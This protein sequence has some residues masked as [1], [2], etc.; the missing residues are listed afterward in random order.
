MSDSPNIVNITVPVGRIE[1]ID[2]SKL[3]SQVI[4]VDLP[5]NVIKIQEG[6]TTNII[7]TTTDTSTITTETVRTNV[8][9]VI[10]QG[11]QGVKGNTGIQGI[12]GPTGPR[13]PY[14]L[15]VNILGVT[16]SQHIYNLSLIH[17]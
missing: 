12:Q 1:V 11:P 14:G 10:D 2:N 9:Q 15:G 6:A 16:S 4:I 7:P 13:G 8:I 17:I 3:S 5:D